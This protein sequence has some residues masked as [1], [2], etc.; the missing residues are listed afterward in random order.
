MASS[1]QILIMWTLLSLALISVVGASST[2]VCIYTWFPLSAEK[3]LYVLYNLPKHLPFCAFCSRCAEEQVPAFSFP[4]AAVAATD[5]I[6]VGR[7]RRRIRAL[8][9]GRLR[10]LLRALVDRIQSE[11]LWFVRPPL[12]HRRASELDVLGIGVHLPGQLV[13]VPR[14]TGDD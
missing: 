12:A 2:S 13:Q 5:V 9:E 8:P 14:R 6:E 7:A 11:V 4:I 1:R 10:V 3:V